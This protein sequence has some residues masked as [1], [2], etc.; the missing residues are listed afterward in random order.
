MAR[1]NRPVLVSPSASHRVEVGAADAAGD[2]LDVDI[3]IAERLGL[4]LHDQSCQD[5]PEGTKDFQATP[6]LVPLGLV[7]L[8]G[9]V[10]GESLKGVR[11]HGESLGVLA[12]LGVIFWYREMSKRV[13]DQGAK[14]KAY[15]PILSWQGQHMAQRPVGKIAIPRTQVPRNEFSLLAVCCGEPARGSCSGPS[16]CGEWGHVRPS[17]AG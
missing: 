10:D 11:I 4:E 14:R 3:A 9:R 12:M 15:N 7:P 17:V 13:V 5:I 6:H 16:P 8:V 2:N 1:D